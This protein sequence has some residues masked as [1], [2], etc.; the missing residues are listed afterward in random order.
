MKKIQRI[1]LAFMLGAL[2]IQVVWADRNANG[3]GDI[4]HK[5]K[6]QYVSCAKE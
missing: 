1:L 6:A 2:P 3:V 4:W 5:A